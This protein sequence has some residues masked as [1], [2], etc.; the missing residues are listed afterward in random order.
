MDKPI[1]MK[2]AE[3]DRG[4]H[5]LIRSPLTGL[6]SELYETMLGT[7]LNLIGFVELN[8]TGTDCKVGLNFQTGLGPSGQ[9][10]QTQGWVY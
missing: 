3:L 4:R 9:T 7:G 10:S 2:L 6:I 1:G 5:H 8:S